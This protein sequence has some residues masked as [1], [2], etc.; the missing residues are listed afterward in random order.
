M[1]TKYYTLRDVVAI[2]KKPVHVVLYQITSGKV[3]EPAIRVGNR[4]AFTVA[5]IYRLAQALEV[6]NLS[7]LLQ[8]YRGAR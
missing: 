7:E 1:N 3:P 4:R 5:D 2:L 8:N 6:K